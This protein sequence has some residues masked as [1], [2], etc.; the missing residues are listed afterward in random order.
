M[1]E[2]QDQF[3]AQVAQLESMARQVMTSQALARYNT[4]KLA[5]QE[6]A[7]QSL[8][9]VVQFAQKNNAQVGD[10]TYKRLLAS[11]QGKRDVRIRR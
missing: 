1:S 7:L 5:H 3:A 2:Q 8:M 9:M 10:D 6:R 11:M 4:L